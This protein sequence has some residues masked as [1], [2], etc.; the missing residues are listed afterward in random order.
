MFVVPVLRP[1]G[2]VP[3]GGRSGVWRSHRLIG[4]Y[5]CTYSENAMANNT[6]PQNQHS[7]AISRTFI[8]CRNALS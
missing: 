7:R 3:R 8:L 1:P 6:S 4:F 5:D 2:V